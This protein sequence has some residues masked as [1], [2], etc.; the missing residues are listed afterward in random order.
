VPVLEVLE[1]QIRQRLAA[2]E[3]RR[4]VEADE[5]RRG[6][7]ELETRAA[8]Y[9]QVA[10][11]LMQEAIRPRLEKLAGF[12]DNAQ[13]PA[14]SGGRHTCGYQFDRTHRF[15]AQ[16]TLRLS[17]TRDGQARMV[18]L[19]YDVTIVPAFGPMPRS[20]RL[21]MPLVGID[22]ERVA[23]WV[24]EKLLAF[25]DAY[26]R[27]ETAE[28]YQIDNVVTDPVCGMAVNKASAPARM[29]YRGTV[30]CFCVE[31]CRQRFAADPEHYLSAQSA[32]T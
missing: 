5:L 27:L 24:E 29:D 22:E 14:G 20:D 26:L 12:F 17:I 13:V 32:R 18:E 31:Q 30:Y 10:D 8:R 21:V 15:P 1:Q 28:P 11:R 9:T 3:E 23:S 19:C 16:A 2:S 6:M 4:R 7:N 25:L